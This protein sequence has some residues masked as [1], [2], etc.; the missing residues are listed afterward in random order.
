MRNYKGYF[1]DY[2]FTL[3][4]RGANTNSLGINKLVFGIVH[5]ENYRQI[6]VKLGQ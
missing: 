4:N 3:V 2:F 5:S 6:F 1:K